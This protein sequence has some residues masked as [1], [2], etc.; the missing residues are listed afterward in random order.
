MTDDELHERI[1]VARARVESGEDPDVAFAGISVN[2]RKW[3]HDPR[4][5]FTQPA[6]GIVVIACG[7]T[8]EELREAHAR[9][10]AGENESS[11]WADIDGRVA[12]RERE[13]LGVTWPFAAPNQYRQS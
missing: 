12:Q 10:A 9:I 13:R 5:K 1:Q 8:N 4:E 2:W 11:V 3:M 6:D 7:P